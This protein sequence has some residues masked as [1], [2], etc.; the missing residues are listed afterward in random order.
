ME[1]RE[2]RNS[3][4]MHCSFRKPERSGVPELKGSTYLQSSPAGEVCRE[5][6]CSAV[7]SCRCN[8]DSAEGAE[9]KW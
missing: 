6:K 1:K 8:K 2:E 7:V 3:V 9:R 5:F 4:P